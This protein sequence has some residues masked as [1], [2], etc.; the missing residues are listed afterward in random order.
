MSSSIIELFQLATSF[1]A[2]RQYFGYLASSSYHYLG[3]T[4]SSELSLCSMV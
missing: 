1:P 2:G 4:S 3:L